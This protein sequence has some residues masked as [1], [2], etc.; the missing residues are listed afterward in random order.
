MNT[1]SAERPER[2]MDRSELV[3][4]ELESLYRVSEVL[5]TQLDLRNKIEAVLEILQQHLGLKSGMVTLRDRETDSM[6]I[7]A[8]YAEVEEGLVD[9]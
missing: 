2:Q 8:L 6:M 4:V 1:Q 7:C 9:T 5:N 3:E